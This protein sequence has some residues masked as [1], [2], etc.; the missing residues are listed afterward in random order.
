MG[1]D[2]IINLGVVD[3]AYAGARGSAG[4]TTTGEVAKILEDKY[5]VMETFFEARK[6]AIA[7]A[8]AESVERAI[9]ELMQ[10]GQVIDPTYRAE[11]KIDAEFRAFL[12]ND[13]MTK[14][15]GG[16]SPSESAL[17][18]R[19]GTFTGAA[20]QGISHRKKHPYAKKN[21]A[22]P[23]FVDTGLYRASF[24]SWFQE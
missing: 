8:A 14:L 9:E 11:Q 22:R 16:L 13:E 20:M 18:G 6:D 21:K 24:R 15:V 10:F 19:G 2:V 12:T 17:L 23:A 1:P 3:V 4:A 5:H 7:A